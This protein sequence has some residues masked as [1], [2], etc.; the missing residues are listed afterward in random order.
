MQASSIDKPKQRRRPRAVPA[1]CEQ[2]LKR[3]EGLIQTVAKIVETRDPYTAGHQQR[4][5]A[6][7]GAIAADRYYRG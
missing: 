7:A 1:S 5:A 3:T 4:V 6:L 2:K